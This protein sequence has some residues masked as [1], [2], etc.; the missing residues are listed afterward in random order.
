MEDFPQPPS[1]QMVMDM[2]VGGCAGPELGIVGVVT[3][4]CEVKFVEA[5]FPYTVRLVVS[6][7]PRPKTKKDRYREFARVCGEY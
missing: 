7:T 4:W 5:T 1:P 3:G 2:G 6:W